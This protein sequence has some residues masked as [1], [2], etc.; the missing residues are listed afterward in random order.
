LIVDSDA[1]LTFSTALQRFQPIPWQCHE[2]LQACGRFQ[3][4][5]PHFRLPLEAGELANILAVGE[6]FGPPVPI[7]QDHPMPPA[8]NYELRMS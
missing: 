2:I 8:I 7:A 3:S 6:T 5:E 1:E 4:I